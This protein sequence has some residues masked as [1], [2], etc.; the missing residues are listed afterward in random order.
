MVKREAV[1]PV[2]LAPLKFEKAVKGL[3]GGDPSAI[4]PAGKKPAPNKAKPPRPVK[5]RDDQDIDRADSEGMAQPQA[6]RP[7][8]KKEGIKK[9]KRKSGK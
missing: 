7:A 4:P 3:L 1:R 6:Q 8:M 5:N 2:S 9:A